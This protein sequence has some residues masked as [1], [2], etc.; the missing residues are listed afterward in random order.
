M[1]NDENLDPV[2]NLRA[3]F[4]SGPKAPKL[5]RRALLRNDVVPWHQAVD[6]ALLLDSLAQLINQY[7]VL[8]AFAAEA[9]AL[10]II[11]TY[12]FE[13][14]DVTAYVGIE[15]PEKRCGKTTLLSVLAELVSRPVIA[16]NISPPALF[17]VIEEATPTLLIDEADTFLRGN[18]EMRGILN[19]GYTRKTAYVIRVAPETAP[20]PRPSD[21]ASLPASETPIPRHSDSPVLGDSDSPPP[22][23]SD[24]PS[25]SHIP[26]SRLI[27][28]SSW[29]P[30]VMA[31]IG[32]LPETLADRCIAIKME[33]KLPDEKCDRL[34]DLCAEDLCRK[35]ARFVLD[36][37]EAIASRRPIIPSQLNDRCADIWEPLLAIADVADGRWPELGRQAAEGLSH[38]ASQTN[39]VSSLLLE[40]LVIFCSAGSGK[41]FSHDII[42]RLNERLDR[43]WAELAKGR[44]IDEMWLA[45]QLRQYD[46][47]PRLIR[48]ADRVGRGYVEADFKPVFQRYIPKSEAR[49]FTEELRSEIT[50]QDPPAPVELETAS[51]KPPLDL[52]T[53]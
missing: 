21:S 29:C 51:E 40:M 41:V 53:G 39:P 10:W 19:S 5:Q 48:Q 17:R 7:V 30:K 22:R 24:S 31:A 37:A 35:C 15:S 26:P 25:H 45:R 9:L 36:N 11:H 13:L 4:A 46:I 12:A 6:G 44:P 1:H 52:V 32:H 20:S 34:R 50:Q 47:R 28:F 33:R 38:A 27:R 42:T 18:E 16:A 43:P 8:P 2:A 14:R 3:R 23:H 49:S